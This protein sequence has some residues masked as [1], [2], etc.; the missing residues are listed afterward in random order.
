MTADWTFITN[1]GAVLALVADRGQITSREIAASLGVTERTVLRIIA[2]LEDA[3]Y[4][5]RFR[6]GRQNYYKV[7]SGQPLRREE[8]SHV[9]VGD[10]VD[11]LNAR[12]KTTPTQNDAAPAARV[13]RRQ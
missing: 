5:Q 8:A 10:L 3:D 6:D 2:D 1:H 11:L 13:T 4:V 12:S 9:S 7:D